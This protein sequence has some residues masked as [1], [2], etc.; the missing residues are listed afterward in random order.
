MRGFMPSSEQCTSFTGICAVAQ[1]ALFSDILDLQVFAGLPSVCGQ[2][3]DAQTYQASKRSVKKW[4]RSVDAGS[5]VVIAASFLLRHFQRPQS[6][7]QL[8]QE[9]LQVSLYLRWCLYLS[10]LVIW[11]HSTALLPPEPSAVPASDFA[12]YGTSAHPDLDP[13]LP[14]Q[15]RYLSPPGPADATGEQ[16]AGFQ[17]SR[18]ETILKRLSA[19]SAESIA[20]D[21][22]AHYTRPILERVLED[23]DCGSRWELIREGADLIRK[24][25]KEH[26]PEERYCRRLPASLESSPCSLLSEDDSGE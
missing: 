18:A 2:I 15:G 19:M 22:S 23:L 4:A 25:L 1:I 7:H 24:L 13:A 16:I 3:I 14:L 9:T 10:A 5:A 12:A 17:H 11:A 26:P 20:K 6:A 21:G 8:V